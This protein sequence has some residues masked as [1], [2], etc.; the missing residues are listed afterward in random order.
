[1]TM[2][3]SINALEVAGFRPQVPIFLPLVGGTAFLG[4]FVIRRTVAVDERFPHFQFK[5]GQIV[6]KRSETEITVTYFATEE[7][8]I[9]LHLPG[10]PELLMPFTALKTNIY[11]KCKTHEFVPLAYIDHTENKSDMLVDPE[12]IMNTYMVAS[13]YIVGRDPSLVP[14][15]PNQHFSTSSQ[16]YTRHYPPLSSMPIRMFEACR[17]ISCTSVSI[18]SKGSINQSF[19]NTRCVHAEKDI[20]AIIEKGID[21]LTKYLHVKV[22]ATDVPVT[23]N[24]PQR[25][26]LPNTD[27]QVAPT[28]FRDLNKGR[29]NG[30]LCHTTQ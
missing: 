24:I 20:F 3:T 18:I 22:A 2:C 30:K 25:H 26:G 9:H 17:A 15:P 29:K 5:V 6:D 28:K 8:C 23:V 19:S 14:F 11:E 10:M 4:D 7:H 13:Q 12:G 21:E 27:V 1:M 16:V